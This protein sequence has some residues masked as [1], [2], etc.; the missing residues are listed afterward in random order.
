MP[1]RGGRPEK[2]P[3]ERLVPLSLRVTA[4]Q[5]DE[6]YRR[7]IRSGKTAGEYVRALLRAAFGA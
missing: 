7:A 1:K 5:A 6:L 4:D 3:H 2:P